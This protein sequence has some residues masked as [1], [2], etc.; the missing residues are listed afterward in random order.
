MI[1]TSNDAAN[2]DNTVDLTNNHPISE[3]QHVWVKIGKH[4]HPAT[5]VSIDNQ[6]AT[7]KWSATNK[8]DEVDLH[9]IAPM[10]DSP[11]LSSRIRRT[12]RRTSRQTNKFLFE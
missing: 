3:K 12:S 5:V 6:I 9:T 10:F 2:K 1:K 7:I 4:E 11:G 8:Q